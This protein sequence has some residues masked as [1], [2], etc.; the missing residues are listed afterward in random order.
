MNNHQLL[1]EAEKSLQQ[2]K[3]LNQ[4]DKKIAFY[5]QTINK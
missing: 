1:L 5:D 3:T 2:I 4:I